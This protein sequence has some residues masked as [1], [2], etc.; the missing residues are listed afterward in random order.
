MPVISPESPVT[1]R[2]ALPDETDVVIVG[3]GI[4]GVMTAW[5]L[6]KAGK[7]V[8]ICEKG[9]VAGEQSCRNWGFV[10]QAGR[11]PAE[12]PI[13]MDCMGI[14][15]DLQNEI[16]DD[17]GFRR[18]GSMF[19]SKHE[20]ELAAYGEWAEEIGRPHG[21]ATRMITSR[22]MDDILDMPHA[23]FTGALYT[24]GD[25]CA[26]PFTAVPAIARCLHAK[27]GVTI[28]EDC[29]VR[30]LDIEAGRITGVHTEDGAVKAGQVMVS[31]GLWS[32]RLLHN[33]GLH[34][35]QL[36]ANTTTARTEPAD[37]QRSLTFGHTDACFRSR[38]DGGYNLMPG[39]IMEHELCFDTLACGL[40]FL[41]ALR[42]YRKHTSVV[43]A[44]YEGFGR[45]MFPKRRWTKDEVT[46]FEKTRVLDPRHS[47]RHFKK[48]KKRIAHYFPELAQLKIEE[49]WTGATDMTPDVL[50]ALGDVEKYP[51]LIIASGLSGHGFGL[52]PGVGKA[53]A[54][55]ILGREPQFDLSRFRFERFSDGSRLS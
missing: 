20:K 23:E 11:D 45:R 48:I 27:G 6:Q 2:D 3:G 53:M 42:K 1:F 24:E 51:G 47:A 31:A 55:H 16:G 8:L 30:L 41:P 44:F 28:R 35:P 34:F 18:P 19:V 4:A 12:L 32:G 10:R 22:E 33:H 36:L 14:W 43:P 49:T 54:N 38:V 50:P 29:A 7:Q 46:P 40:E 39:E 21:L 15:E 25:G 26:E 13:M 52:G 17:V 9:R 37:D 5:F